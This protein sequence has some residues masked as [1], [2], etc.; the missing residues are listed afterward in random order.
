M[1]VEKKGENFHQEVEKIILGADNG[2]RENL[3]RRK[4]WPASPLEGEKERVDPMPPEW[5][6]PQGGIYREW[7]VG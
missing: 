6:K 4:T 1:L 5:R 2:R 3:A 7:G